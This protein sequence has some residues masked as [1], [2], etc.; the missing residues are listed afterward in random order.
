VPDSDFESLESKIAKCPRCGV[1]LG[2]LA[3]ADIKGAGCPKCEGVW[4]SAVDLS[5]AIRLYAADHG[6]ALEAI[7]L[8]E[9]PAAP[10]AL[11]C[12]DCSFSLQIIALRGVDVEQCPSCRGVF[13]D[14]GEIEAIANRVT[15]ASTTWE[16][17]RQ[18]FLKTVRLARERSAQER[19][20][21]APM[22]P[23]WWR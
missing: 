22:R 15:Q 21:G 18:E 9:G 14:G 12:P 4:L 11:P 5:A 6:V 20:K 19:A 16:P 23:P 17:A 8:L 10:T 13:L 3:H 2:T 7:A 1:E